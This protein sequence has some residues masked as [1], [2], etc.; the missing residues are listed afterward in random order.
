MGT[1]AQF[2]P[3]K[4]VPVVCGAAGETGRQPT[5]HLE[6]M[7]ET[8]ESEREFPPFLF[9]PPR[10]AALSPEVSSCGPTHGVREGSRGHPSAIRQKKADGEGRFHL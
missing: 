8:D 10:V 3:G 1:G 4:C 7:T 6:R 9:P 2:D 5:L